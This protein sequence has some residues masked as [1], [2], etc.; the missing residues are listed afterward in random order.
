MFDWLIDKIV[1]RVTNIASYVAPSDCFYVPAAHDRVLVLQRNQMP[2]KPK[3]VTRIVVVSDT[4]GMHEKLGQIPEGDIF[5]HC[6]DILMVG[7]LY[8]MESQRKKVAAFNNWLSTVPC[9]HKIVIAGNH[10]QVLSSIGETES[11]RLLSNAIYLENRGVVAGGLRFWGSPCSELKLHSSN[12]A[13]QNGLYPQIAIDKR[14]SAT[15][16][17]DKIDIL[18]THGH[19]PELCSVIEHRVHLWGH[20]HHSYGIRL[21]G[22]KF[23]GEVLKSLSICAAVPGTNFGLANGPIVVDVIQRDDIEE[24]NKPTLVPHQA[25]AVNNSSSLNDIPIV[26]MDKVGAL[27][28][29]KR[30]F[31]CGKQS[32]V[33]PVNIPQQ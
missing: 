24:N 25:A 7:R 14:P 26:K 19:C 18:I 20:A 32:Q 13:F 12:R 10:D 8:T 22:E 11:S 31:A 27:S 30:L 4:H 21:A 3:N 16:E 33:V 17:R 2:L 23:R 1:N 6:G 9:T 5:I 28:R 15:N 29:F